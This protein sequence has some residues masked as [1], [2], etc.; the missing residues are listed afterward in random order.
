[1][2]A[3]SAPVAKRRRIK[4]FN[5]VILPKILSSTCLFTI[6]T[7]R[8]KYAWIKI[9]Q[10]FPGSRIP[11]QG[12]RDR[13]FQFWARSK[14]SGNHETPGIEGKI[15]CFYGFLTIGIFSRFSANPQDPKFI[16]LDILIPGIRD[17]LILGILIPGIR[18]F[19]SLGIW[20]L[21]KV[22]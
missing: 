3:G 12:I 5:T 2:R 18:D 11:I 6:N 19:L 20:I 1:M 13:G 4:I 8:E 14:N 21:E 9:Q 16:D 10:K 7:L 15:Y 22:L 17:F